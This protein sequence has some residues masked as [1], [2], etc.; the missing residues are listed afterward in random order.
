MGVESIKEIPVQFPK[1]HVFKNNTISIM[2][3]L[4]NFV[5]FLMGRHRKFQIDHSLEVLKS[6]KAEI[7]SFKSSQQLNALILIKSGQYGTLEEVASHLGISHRTLHRWLKRYREDGLERLLSPL[8]RNKPSKII[9]PEIH[10]ALEQRLISKDNPFSGYVEVQQ[11]L[12][13]TYQVKIGYKWLW[14]YM[15][16]KMNSKLKVPRKVNVK[17]DPD[18]EDC[19]FKTA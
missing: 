2:I 11:W 19:F 5:F 16:T 7:T 6:H 14:A 3:C 10:R 18:A 8:T 12:E 9:T 17:K 13:N 1:Q 15:T 4:K